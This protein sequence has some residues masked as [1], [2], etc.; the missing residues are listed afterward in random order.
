VETQTVH[1]PHFGAG[2]LLKTYM[3]GY[4]WEVI[5]ASGRRF[6]LPAKEFTAESY[7]TVHAA[8]H[9]GRAKGAHPARH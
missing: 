5:F 1:H 8:G 7:R 3:S 4:E 2:E 6:R 9:P